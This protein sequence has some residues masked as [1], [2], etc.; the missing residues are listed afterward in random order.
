M[1]LGSVAA[2]SALLLASAVAP[3]AP[4]HAAQPPLPTTTTSIIEIG[5]PADDGNGSVAGIRLQLYDGTD[6]RPTTPVPDTWATCT[7]TDGDPCWFAVPQTQVGGANRGRQFWV[8]R[9]EVPPG[10]Y[11]VDS[12][13]VSGP[14]PIQG[15]P[16]VS[17]PYRFR[18]PPV[19]A[20]QQYR[21]GSRGVAP[22]MDDRVPR[23]PAASAGI[24]QTSRDNPPPVRACVRDIALVV[25]VSF[26]FEQQDRLAELQDALTDVTDALEGTPTR[27]ALIPFANQVSTPP[28]NDTLPLTTV[29]TAAGADAVRGWIGRL[30]G[31]SGGTNWDAGLAAVADLAEPVDLAILITDR[32]PDTYVRAVQDTG[33]RVTSFIDVEQAVLAANALKATGTRIVAAEVRALPSSALEVLGANMRAVSGPVAGSDYFQPASYSDLAEEFREKLVECRSELV[34]ISRPSRPAARSGTRS[35]G[36]GGGSPRRPPPRC[37]LSC[38]ITAAETGAIVFEGVDLRPDTLTFTETPKPGSQPIPNLGRNAVCREI[39][40]D[41]VPV[42]ATNVPNGF[43]LS[44]FRIRGVTCTVSNTRPPPSITVDKT[45]L[46]NGVATAQG[47]EPQQLGAT[48]L[49]GGRSLPWGEPRFDVTAGGSVPIDETRSQLP[50]GCTLESA[51]V[52]SVNGL[53]SDAALPYPLTVADTANSVTITNSLTC[54]TTL[55]LIKEIRNGAGGS[56][57]PAD[58]TVAATGPTPISG[59]T[60]TPAVTA[61]QVVPSV[62]TLAEAGPAGYQAGA[63]SCTGGPL[64]GNQV[65][66]AFGAVVRCTI[67][68]PTSRRGSRCSSRSRTRS[69]D[70]RRQPT[71]R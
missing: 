42:S 14:G 1:R 46:V 51:R 15:S 9:A 19:Q 49:V 38:G 22:F 6:T 41:H 58:W 37:S 18:T 17:A 50:P 34:V 71:G 62:Y 2:A 25:D 70:R 13:M 11:G 43:R 65:P 67:V 56:A 5:V 35:P 10:W 32:S 40:R 26:D 23:D 48:L 3:V 4:A 54:A 66:V 59:V 29:S 24:W 52:T 63:W 47:A 64:A 69:A 7:S 57:T 39:G 61:A 30:T 45:W 55:S 31:E 68:N 33:D 16:F 8:V 60:G 21:S 12:L 53:P 27:L 20:G 44:T 28:L 36:D